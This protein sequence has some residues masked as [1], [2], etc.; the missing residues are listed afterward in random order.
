MKLILTSLTKE[1]QK[2]AYSSMI[3]KKIKSPGWLK[4]LVSRQN[5]CQVLTLSLLAQNFYIIQRET[6][7]L[8]S[9]PCL[10]VE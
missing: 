7:S 10:W 1:W 4:H 8:S 9:S 2:Y 5:Q 6:L 3:Q